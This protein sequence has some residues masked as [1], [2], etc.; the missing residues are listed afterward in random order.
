M[1]SYPALPFL[2]HARHSGNLAVAE[3]RGDGRDQ[4]TD[5]TRA[6]QELQQLRA[7]V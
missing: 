7:L 4:N 6:W 1:P 5:W 2:C 3:R